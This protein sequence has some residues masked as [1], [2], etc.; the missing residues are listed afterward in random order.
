MLVESDKD[1]SKA[2]NKLLTEKV[3]AA[4]NKS[5]EH[6]KQLMSKRVGAPLQDQNQMYQGLS[7]VRSTKKRRRDDFESDA[8]MST[9][10][11][12]SSNHSSGSV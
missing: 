5:D 7:S 10:N 12:H 1:W 9:S 3:N 8:M 11:N 6:S 2:Y 4:T